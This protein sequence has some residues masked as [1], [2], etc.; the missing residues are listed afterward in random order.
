MDLL[1]DAGE[2]VGVV[3]TDGQPGG[4]DRDF[5]LLQQSRG[6]LHAQAGE[7]LRGCLT[8]VP[9]EQ[10]GKI[11]RSDATSAGRSTRTAQD[12]VI[13]HEVFAAAVEGAAAPGGQAGMMNTTALVYSCWLG[14]PAVLWKAPASTRSVISAEVAAGSVSSTE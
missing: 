7:E 11:L 8:G 12:G 3:E 14:T 2:V 6:V 13:R 10:A 4:F 1:E 9:A 5:R